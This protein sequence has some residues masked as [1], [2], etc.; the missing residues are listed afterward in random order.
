MLRWARLWEKV[1]MNSKS[2]SQTVRKERED[3]YIMVRKP[4]LVHLRLIYLQNRKENKT[5][6]ESFPP[7]EKIG[8]F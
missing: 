6:T 3:M 2:Q 4:Q 8:S 7:G 1:P 5:H